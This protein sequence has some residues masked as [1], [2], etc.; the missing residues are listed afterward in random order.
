MAVGRKEWKRSAFIFGRERDQVKISKAGIKALLVSTIEYTMGKWCFFFSLSTHLHEQWQVCSKGGKKS[1]VTASNI[2][3]WRVLMLDIW[4]VFSVPCDCHSYQ[5]RVLYMCYMLWISP[6]TRQSSS[7]STAKDIISLGWI[8]NHVWNTRNT[9]FWSACFLKRSVF[10]LR[11]EKR[12]W[13]VDK[14]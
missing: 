12:P 3:L 8:G 10:H 7:I 6:D 14:F 4:L 1:F 11:E 2:L 9:K 5:D 13:S